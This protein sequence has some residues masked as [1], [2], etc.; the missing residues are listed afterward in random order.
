LLAN[1]PDRAATRAYAERFSWEETTAGQL[2]LFRAV[3][4]G[5][6]AQV[7]ALGTR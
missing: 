5:R 1:R 7:V 2:D 4:Q 6:S 3:L